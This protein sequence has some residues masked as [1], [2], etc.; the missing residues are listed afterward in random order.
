V[1]HA[2]ADARALRA[3][4]GSA[5]AAGKHGWILSNHDFSRLASRAGQQNARA[6][7]LLTLSLPGP[8]FLFQG[9]EIGMADGTTAESLD[10][11][12]RDAFRL[13]MPWDSSPN[14][15]FTS[16]TPWL[17]PLER[18]T[19]NVADQEREPESELAL[20]R[21]LIALR[22][23][24]GALTELLHSPPGTLVVNRGRHI[25]AVNLGDEPR[26]A[27]PAGEIVAEARPGDGSDSRVIPA[28]G[29][30]VATESREHPNAR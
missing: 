9:D 19:T 26:P 18:P 30:W 27:P 4:I 25:V 15:G 24:L 29:G 22:R 8:A 10:R 2:G 28:H 13:P 6:V 20:H 3:G 11:H 16:G 12:G 1:L 14:G 7:S 21:R 5:L 17:K 23:K